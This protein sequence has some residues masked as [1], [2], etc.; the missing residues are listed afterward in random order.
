MKVAIIG[1]GNVGK[2]IAKSAT[3]AGHEVTIASRNHENAQQAAKESNAQAVPSTR[4]A[5]KDA[6]LVVLAIPEDK[7]D[8]LRQITDVRVRI[9]A[10]PN[11]VIAGKVRE[12]SPIADPA[13]RFR[14]INKLNAATGAGFSGAPTSVI[15]PSSFSSCKYAFRS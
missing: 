11:N 6:E 5:V 1:S 12:V 8:A 15:V 13:R 3:R 14:P 4:D 10:N 7:V 9:W 2:A